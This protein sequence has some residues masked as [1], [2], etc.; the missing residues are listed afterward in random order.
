MHNSKTRR[1][2]CGVARNLY[3]VDINGDIY[4]CQRF[5]NNKEFAIG[6]VADGDIGQK[7]FLKKVTIDN[8][9]KCAHCWARNLCV[10]G[11]P[12]ENLASTGDMNL[13]HD[14]YCRYVKKIKSELIRLYLRLSDE[15][16]EI[17]FKKK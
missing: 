11:C 14:S 4:P 16:I 5:V 17:L 3:A 13:P 12:H 15:D 6:N 9:K 7:D 2:S 1:V 10:A 8:F